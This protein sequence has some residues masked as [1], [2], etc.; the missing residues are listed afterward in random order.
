MADVC[1]DIF[2]ILSRNLFGRAPHAWVI[3]QPFPI[4]DLAVKMQKH[5]LKKK[6]IYLILLSRNVCVCFVY[7]PEK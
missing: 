5:S 7:E 2:A 3:V 1:V 4:V 6:N